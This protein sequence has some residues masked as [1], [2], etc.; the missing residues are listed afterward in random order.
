M[1]RIDA[2]KVMNLCEIKAMFGV[3]SPANILSYL[4]Q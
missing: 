1:K 2:G 4:A 3:I